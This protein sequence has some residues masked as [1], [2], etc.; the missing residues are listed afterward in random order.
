MSNERERL[1][2]EELDEITYLY[3]HQGWKVSHIAR[4]LLKNRAT[5]HWRIKTMGLVR[6]V[7]EVTAIPME[8]YFAYKGYQGD[9]LYGHY[10]KAEK[11][12]K[13]KAHDCTHNTYTIRRIVTCSHCKEEIENR[14]V[15]SEKQDNFNHLPIKANIS[16]E[17]NDADW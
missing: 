11:D 6:E 1:T 9:D 5:L 12:K 15:G 4:K 7:P 10:L 8:I 16:N 2:P 3:T 17:F 13:K 14:I